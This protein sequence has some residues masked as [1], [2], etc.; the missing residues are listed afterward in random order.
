MNTEEITIKYLADVPEVIPIIA[1]KTGI[2]ELF[3]YTPNAC[4]FYKRI[5]WTIVEELQYMSR[6][7]VIM[8]RELSI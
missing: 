6:D 1:K 8:K 3:L 7:V 4:D 5:G 2:T